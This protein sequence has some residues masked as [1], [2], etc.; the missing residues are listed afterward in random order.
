[1]MAPPGTYLARLSVDGRVVG[2]R[3]FRL[4][5]DPRVK[6]VTLADHAEQFRFLRRVA[7][8]FSD[9]NNAV[10]TIRNLRDDVDDRR[11][12]LQGQPR[13]TFDQ[14]ANALMETLTSVEDS[15][16]Q[17]RS[18]SGQDPLNYPIRLNNK[19]GALMGVVGSSDGRPTAQS[20]EVFEMLNARLEAELRRMRAAITT[21][22]PP[23]NA[24]LRDNRLPEISPR[25]TALTP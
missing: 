15:I 18:R 23:I 10:I 11:N 12:R 4:L 21:H 25:M 1:M 22:L 19:I 13:S 9:A 3:S 16:Y 17:T 7:N 5:P 6:G 8:R 2:Q 20:Y 24:V 14:H